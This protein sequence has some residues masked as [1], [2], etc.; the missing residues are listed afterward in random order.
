MEI[1]LGAFTSEWEAR[2]AAFL[3]ERAKLS[4]RKGVDEEIDEAFSLRVKS[5]GAAEPV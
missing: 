4:K 5:A 1:F 3:L 2:K